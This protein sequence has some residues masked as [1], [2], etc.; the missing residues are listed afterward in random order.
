MSNLLCDDFVQIAM[1]QEYGLAVG[2]RKFSDMPNG[3]ARNEVIQKAI[4][5]DQKATR[6]D[7]MFHTTYQAPIGYL[8]QKQK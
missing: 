7:E 3:C 1:T 8:S 5:W 6:Y 2:A 4:S